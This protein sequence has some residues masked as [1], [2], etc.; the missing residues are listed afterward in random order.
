MHYLVTGGTGFI[1]RALSAQLASDG[2]RVSVLTRQSAQRPAG[3]SDAI[4]LLAGLDTLSSVDVVINLQGE[5]LGQGRWSAARK[6]AIRESRIGFTRS[7]VE[8]MSALES[9]PQLLISGSAIGWYGSRGDQELIEDAEPGPDDDFG[10]RLC[11]EWE[12]EALTAKS[13]GIRV[14]CIRTGIVLDRA[15]GP[16]ARML[17]PFR[18][19]AGGRLGSGRQW[20]SWITLH[21]M[22]RLL[23]HVA[24][25]QLS[26]AIN[27]VAPEPV[28]NAEFTEV[29]A[30]ALG[31][32]ALLPMPAFMLR[33]MFGQMSSLLL[34]SQRVI[35]E[36][37]RD[38][39]FEFDHSTLEVGIEAALS[40]S[41]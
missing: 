29:L 31:R 9:R 30:E 12:A 35:P 4:E 20:M 28:T 33:L 25:R 16:L 11:H 8:W 38:A 21:D 13:H 14:A 39:G 40:G 32:P 15:G 1:G 3:L 7:L 2:H 5:N 6:Q 27:A 22:V 10:A 41:G 24:D 34:G 37:I 19:G 23:R 26:G 18:M 17:P 36:A